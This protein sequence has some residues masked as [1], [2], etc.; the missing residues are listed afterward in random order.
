M[1]NAITLGGTAKAAHHVQVLD[2]SI[3]LLGANTTS[4]R[5]NVSLLDNNLQPLV[6]PI[7]HIG[8]AAH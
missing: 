1:V 6:R 5:S 4:F 7:E 2:N 3:L 8:S